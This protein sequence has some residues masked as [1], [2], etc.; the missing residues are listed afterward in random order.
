MKATQEKPKQ[1]KHT[2]FINQTSDANTID[3]KFL[4]DKGIV[5]SADEALALSGL[6]F[7]EKGEQIPNKN[8]G[9]TYLSSIGVAIYDWSMGAKMF[10]D[11]VQSEMGKSVFKKF[12]PDKY[13]LFF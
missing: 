5:L 12:F 2:D 3:L 8:G 10:G 11:K 1:M 7:F 4:I 6:M 9:N 13:D